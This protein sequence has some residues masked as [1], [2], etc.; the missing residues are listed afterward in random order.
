[1]QLISNKK[2]SSALEISLL[3]IFTISILCATV[4]TSIRN[5]IP[6]SLPIK[7]D[8]A[9]IT[10][11]VPQG[12]QWVSFNEWRYNKAHNNFLL[13]S[14]IVQQE[15]KVAFVEL[16]YI[17][18]PITL[19]PAE[20]LDANRPP[21][22][23]L[24][25][26]QTINRDG[27]DIFWHRI[28]QESIAAGYY[29]GVARLPADR[30]LQIKIFA[31]RDEDLAERMFD[32]IMKGLSFE[33]NQKLEDGLNFVKHLKE[34]KLPNLI[35]DETGSSMSRVYLVNVTEPIDS[36]VP[37][38]NI[39]DGF[40]IEHFS[41]SNDPATLP[42]QCKSFFL[43]N[44]SS[45]AAADT[46]FQ[47]DLSFDTFTW[48]ARRTTLSG[49]VVSLTQI[50]LDTEGILS[51]SN[52]YAEP[53]NFTVTPGLLTIP[54]ILLDTVATQLLDY[55]A[56]S[57][58]IDLLFA[59]GRIT[60]VQLTKFTPED[61]DV[62]NNEIKFAVKTQYLNNPDN[63]QVTYFDKNHEILTKVEKTE[64]TVVGHRSNARD[65]INAFPER[66]EH[67]KEILK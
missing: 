63:S 18:T 27:I 20:L 33:T 43:M 53:T 11:S 8:L 10:A 2:Q 24:V 64:M 58:Y 41:F 5:K 37:K 19:D 51:Y 6:M 30:M 4:I 7:L 38:K 22:S 34:E 44:T 14:T 49:S 56:E 32:A 60:P 3:A 35:R 45:G 54:E 57:V 17:L 36:K 40:V 47:S 31:Y 59:D 39:F 55:P 50:E 26:S 21:G 46:T 28:R 42:I 62:Q 61:E 23:E 1:M 48:R 15:F 12:R 29:V 66:K 16:V 52:L 67:I 9:S 25:S 13:A 65:L